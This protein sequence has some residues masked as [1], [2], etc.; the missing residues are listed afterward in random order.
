M[1]SPGEHISDLRNAHT[2][3]IIINV[4]LGEVYDLFFSILSRAMITPFSFGFTYFFMGKTCAV[5]Y[6]ELS[7]C[8]NVDD[9]AIRHPVAT[10]I[11]ADSLILISNI[12]PFT[13]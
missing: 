9:H 12:R 5:P 6:G 7:S 10:H 4:E 3:I 8:I 1:A 11:C 13:P 2:Q